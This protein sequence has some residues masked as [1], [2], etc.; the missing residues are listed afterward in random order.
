[1]T[2]DV[3]AAILG[4]LGY[5]VDTAQDLR[6]ALTEA[7][8]RKRDLPTMLVADAGSQVDLPFLAKQAFIVD[9]EGY[10]QPLSVQGGALTAPAE[11]GYYLLR[12]DGQEMQLAVA[13]PVCPA[14]RGKGWGVSVQIPS[15]RG[16]TGRAFGN[17][18]ELAQLADALGT[19]G[20]AALA[21]NPVHALFPG[22]GAGFS[23]YSPSS[24]L[25]LNTAMGDPELVGLPGL[26]SEPVNGLIDWPTALPQRY[27]ALERVFAGLDMQRRTGILQACDAGGDLLRRHAIFD[28]LDR[29]FRLQG[30]SGWQDWPAAYRDPGSTTVSTWT[31]QHTAEVE[32]QLFLQWLAQQG[33]QH[34][35][36]AATDA[37]MEWGLIG[38]LAVGVVPGGSDCW[39][40]GSAM[41]QG[42]TIG[43]PPDPLGPHGQNWGITTFSPD[44]LRKSGYAPFIAMLQASFA[45]GGGLRIDHAFG[46]ARLW[47]V[48]Q[49]GGASDG[50]YL[51]YPFEDLMRLVTLE[52]HRA[53]AL[54]IAED[55]GTSPNG[56]TATI[57]Q[58]QMLGMRVLHFERAGDAG[59]IGAHDY[60]ANAVALTGTHDTATVAG[61]WSGRDLDWAAQCDRLPSEISRTEAERIRDWDR[62]RLWATMR[63]N[64][65]RPAPDDTGPAVDAAIA[66]IAST[67]AL[68]TLTPMEDLLGEVEQPNLPGTTIEHPNWRR[69]YPATAEQMLRVDAVNHRVKLAANRP[70]G[71]S[72]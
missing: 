15:L 59:F 42:L 21:I 60:P 36:R 34:A 39:S 61:W 35:Q 69:R 70:L 55:L 7:E 68:L 43:A 67:P 9:Q 5:A 48:P 52:A 8:A 51:S 41:L 20:A 14:P 58:R 57:S 23:P 12:L 4:A 29:H 28:A 46:L 38:D 50:A 16:K 3:L 11:A 32:L 64:S 53:G 17:F 25:F 19:R 65:M 56:F 6:T 2:N 33:L 31:H 45:T 72:E 44:G 24:R 54:V 47:V 63:G 62:G 37:G 40:L 49:G 10:E 18:A 71:Q 1:M 66:H 26:P 30:A 27:L 22:T 13:P